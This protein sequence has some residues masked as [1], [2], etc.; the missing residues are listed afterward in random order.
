ME[1]I[2][3]NSKSLNNGFIKHV[4]N[5]DNETKSSLLNTAQYVVLAIIPLTI[6]NHLVNSVIAEFDES[7][8]NVEVLVEII[9]ELFAQMFGLF[10][11]HRLITYVPT[12]SGRS[13]GE[14]NLFTIILI[15]I[16]VLYQTDSQVGKKIK[17]LV[18][19]GIEIW[20]GKPKEEKEDE[21]K[22]GKSVVKVTQPIS[23]GGMPTHQPSRADYLQ[24]HNAM[25]SPTQMMPPANEQS[26]A[27]NNMYNSGGFNGLV[28]ANAPV[29]QEPMAANA[30]FGAFSAF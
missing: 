23:R 1:D 4:F 28:D 26:G 3:N 29:Q 19:R 7:K 22:K 2:E 21:K 11:I 14:L 27:S 30:G 5:F 12:Y 24:S 6:Y 9:G 18:S 17:L 15:Y 20:E 13:M 8:G 25:S 10:F 16:S